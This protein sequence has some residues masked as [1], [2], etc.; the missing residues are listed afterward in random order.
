MKYFLAYETRNGKLEKIEKK[1]IVPFSSDFKDI[2]EFTLSFE[3]ILDLKDFLYKNKLIP[4][5]YFS[6]YYGSQAKKDDISTIKKISY[7]ELKF[8]QDSKFYNPIYLKEL[9]Q[10]NVKS[11]NFIN[12]IISKYLRKLGLKKY[13]YEDI[14]NRLNYAYEMGT[15]SKELEELKNYFDNQQINNCIEELL[16]D[17]KSNYIKKDLIH[18]S[19][20]DIAEIILLQE[21]EILNYYSHV[22]D[23][24]LRT[25]KV[26]EP[27]IISELFKIRA[28]YYYNKSVK[29][30]Y[31]PVSFE[32]N[33]DNLL[34]LIICKYGELKD[35]LGNPIIK[36]GKKQKDFIVKDG[37][38]V[39]KARELYDLGT[40]LK[41]YEENKKYYEYSEE[42]RKD[43]NAA[44]D[45]NKDD[46]EEFLT[47]DDYRMLNRG[48]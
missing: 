6:V 9:L 33:V 22:R 3:S 48:L 2:L 24:L 39:V 14:L 20:E 30:Y 42:V 40:F 8:K 16:Y 36:N 7:P 23:R 15:L 35:N 37:L 34:K 12:L 18:I 31:D 43:I 44:I 11:A 13:V 41:E 38:Y 1:D 4:E 10:E 45:E 32:E 26:V 19:I 21:S 47:E 29:E 5:R 27:P 17:L 46:F 25:K 28:K